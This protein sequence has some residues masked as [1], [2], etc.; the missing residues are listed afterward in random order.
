MVP[1]AYQH[2]GDFKLARLLKFNKISVNVLSFFFGTSINL[3]VS[4]QNTVSQNTVV[5]TVTQTSNFR[6]KEKTMIVFSPLLAHASSVTSLWGG[7][8]VCAMLQ[9]AHLLSKQASRSPSGRLLLVLKM[10]C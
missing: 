2:N 8:R 5:C 7:G 4:P 3:A 9:Q 1:S 10:I 6:G